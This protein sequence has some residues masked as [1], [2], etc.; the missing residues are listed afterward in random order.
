MVKHALRSPLAPAAEASE[1]PESP[2]PA[3]ES[4]PPATATQRPARGRQRVR[5]RHA[6]TAGVDPSSRYDL[7]SFRPYASAVFSSTNKR[8]AGSRGRT[9]RRRPISRWPATEA[10][11]WACSASTH[12][13]SS[14]DAS[15]ARVRREPGASP[16]RARRPSGRILSVFCLATCVRAACTANAHPGCVPSAESA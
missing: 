14:L 2:E 4:H 16:A 11:S 10:A 8:C 6:S 15:R 5:H 12:A 3:S 13:R 1:G 9:R 7:P